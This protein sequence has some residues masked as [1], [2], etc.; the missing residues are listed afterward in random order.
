MLDVLFVSGSYPDFEKNEMI[1]ANVGIENGKITYIGQDQPEAA[2]VIDCTGKVV[3]PGFIDIHMHEEDIKEGDKWIIADM[4]LSQGVTLAVGG[5]CGVMKQPV[6]EFKAFMNRMGGCPIN[7][8]I[9]SGYNYYRRNVLGFGEYEKTDKATW[10]KIREFMLEDLD[11]GAFGISFGI[12]YDPGITT[13]EIKYAT[14]LK[15][16]DSLLVAAHYRWDNANAIEAIEEMIEIQE[17]MTKKFQISHL[18]SCA[19]LGQMKESLELINGYM[20]KNPKLNYDTYPYNAFSTYIGSTVFEDGCFE[21]WKKDYDSILLTVAPYENVFCTKEIFEDA[22][23]NYPDM[24][25]VAFVM[26]EDEIADAVANPKGM[27]ASDGIINNGLGHPRAKGTFPRVLGK[28]VREEGRLSLIDALRKMTLE[29]A[30][31]LELEDRKGVIKVGADAD[32]TVFDPETIADGPTFQNIN[33]PNKG[34]D[35]VYVNGKLA[36]DGEN[37]VSR[38]NGEFIAHK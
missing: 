14:Q 25:A 11:E 31:R 17:N 5:N 1:K 26:N 24:L 38:T 21:E 37:I 2:K 20:E 6:K 28:Y 7:Y 3:S 9:L 10:D 16:D 12:E 32:I 36:L 27:V 30:V 15:D 19:A 23:A 8:I 34:I 33:L 18:S 4:M 22:R 13:E 35:C 29:P